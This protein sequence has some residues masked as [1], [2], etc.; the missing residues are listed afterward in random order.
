MT[1]LL[2]SMPI[3]ADLSGL[4]VTWPWFDSSMPLASFLYVID[5]FQLK[6]IQFTRNHFKIVSTIFFKLLYYN[7]LTLA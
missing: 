4:L 7:F 2:D 5:V 6:L 3:T 1:R